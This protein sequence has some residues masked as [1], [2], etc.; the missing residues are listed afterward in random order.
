M[1]RGV[2]DVVPNAMTLG[3]DPCDV[4]STEVAEKESTEER[5]RVSA[6]LAVIGALES[7]SSFL[8]VPRHLRVFLA[9]RMNERGGEG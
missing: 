1:H 4:R 7:V 6:A 2:H 8:E 9:K 3:L 5:L